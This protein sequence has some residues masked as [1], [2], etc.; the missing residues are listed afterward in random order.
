M[1]GLDLQALVAEASA[2]DPA[3]RE[4]AYTELLRLVSIFVRA[5]MS[6]KLRDHRESADVCQSIAKSFVDDAS[7]GMLK[8]DS[9]AALNGYL[10]QVVRTKL[11]EFAR[12]DTADKRGGGAAHGHDPDLAAAPDPTASVRALSEEAFDR[13]KATLTAEEQELVSLRRRGM[14]WSA[15]A[16]AV[17]VPEAALRQRWS[18]MQKRLVEVL[19]GR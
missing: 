2:A 10:Q 7:R 15:I 3:A 16:A 5:R 19:E 14:E 12:H 1:A 9:P 18:R 8:F 17:G 13:V 4:R 6:D 11:A